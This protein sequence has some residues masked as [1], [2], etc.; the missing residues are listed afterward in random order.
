MRLVTILFVALFGLPAF[1]Q[2][3]LPEIGKLSDIT[4][5]TRFYIT[6]DA[7]NSKYMIKELKKHSELTQVYKPEDADFFI[8]YKSLSRTAPTNSLG[9]TTETGQLD[10]Y[11]YQEKRKVI[12]WSD[13][14]Y[15]TLDLPSVKL[16]AKFL[17]AFSPNKK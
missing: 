4:G 9:L 10:V 11:F 8:E 15:S 7:M 1:A 13:S 14:A 2:S 3:D 16:T 12:A 5:K 17:K 6:A